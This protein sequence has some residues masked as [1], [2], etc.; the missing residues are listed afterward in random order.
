MTA[1]ATPWWQSPFCQGVVVASAPV[2]LQRVGVLRDRDAP[3]FAGALCIGMLSAGV[4]RIGDGVV[5]VGD[6]VA[7]FGDRFGDSVT[8]FGDR[9]GDSVTHLGDGVASVGAALDGVGA[10]VRAYGSRC[11]GVTTGR[12]L[13]AC[14]SASCASAP[15]ASSARREAPESEAPRATTPSKAP[16]RPPCPRCGE[17]HDDRQGPCCRR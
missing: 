6:G 12:C 1:H 2:V 14:P 11:A 16:P 4:M 8:H 7:H 5:R 9:F 17:V 15:V 10:G 3:L 13:C